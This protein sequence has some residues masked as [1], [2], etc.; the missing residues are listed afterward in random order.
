[1][2]R[3]VTPPGGAILDPF[4]ASGT[5]GVAAIEVDFSFI[6]IEREPEY[7]EVSKRR[8]EAATELWR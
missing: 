5:T 1:M 7:T 4:A 6:A 2:A 8:L 3:L